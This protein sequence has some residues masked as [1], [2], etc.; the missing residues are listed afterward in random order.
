MY[1]NFRDVPAKWLIAYTGSSIPLWVKLLKICA[2]LKLLDRNLAV[3]GRHFYVQR[4]V[5]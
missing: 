1:I 5:L 3:K 4:K 2:D